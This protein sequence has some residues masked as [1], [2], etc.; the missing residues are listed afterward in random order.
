[1]IRTISLPSSETGFLAKLLSIASCTASRYFG[2]LVRLQHW[3]KCLSQACILLLLLLTLIDIHNL[4]LWYFYYHN[5]VQRLITPL[6][7]LVLH[8]QLVVRPRQ[9]H[10]RLFII[11][12]PNEFPPR[13]KVTSLLSLPVVMAQYFAC[14]AYCW[15]LKSQKSTCIW[16][17]NFTFIY[18]SMLTDAWLK[19]C[20]DSGILQCAPIE[21]LSVYRHRCDKAGDGE[22]KMFVHSLPCS[23][24]TIQDCSVLLTGLLVFYRLYQLL[25]WRLLDTDPF[26][27]QDLE[28][29][30]P[31][32][33]LSLRTP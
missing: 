28:L 2:Y 25:T 6:Q 12:R 18:T 16:K 22:D 5:G 30:I 13:F 4:I 19:A 11:S 31:L 26:V 17:F 9:C 1:V 15:H 29:R 20:S 23:D 8:V 21:Y 7:F 32:N 27:H 14:G 24:V 10:L 33:L 3:N